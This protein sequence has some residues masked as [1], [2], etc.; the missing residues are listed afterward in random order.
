MKVLSMIQPWASLFL[1]N[2][3]QYET[4][5]WNTKYRGPLAIHTSKKLDS[6]A[7]NDNTIQPLLR[8]H[9]LDKSNLPTGQII[10]VCTLINCFKV[11]ENNHVSAV[12]EDGRI[13]SG[14]NYFLGDFRVGNYVWEVSNKELLVNYIPAKGKLGLWDYDIN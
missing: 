12:L 4:R 2:E 3:V 10:G 9:G 8:K 1:S 6:A 5:T 11:I 13:V 7:C 14:N